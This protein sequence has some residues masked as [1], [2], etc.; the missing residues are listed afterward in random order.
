M[1]EF[2]QTNATSLWWLASFSI[3][4]FIASLAVIPLLAIRIPPDYFTHR[5]RH[6]APWA[7]QHPLVRGI[8]IT[9]KN[10]FG[11]VFIVVGTAMLILPGQGLLTILIGLILVDFPGKYRFERWLVSRHRVLRSINW[12][13]R[14]TNRE[15]LVVDR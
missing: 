11:Y 5:K 8:F 9:G 4:T 6:R 15:P 7:N 2:A 3:I 1:L 13:R 14:R 10:V 12:L